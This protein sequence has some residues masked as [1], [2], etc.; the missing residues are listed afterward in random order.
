MFD[1]IGIALVEHSPQGIER[2]AGLEILTQTDARQRDR[3]YCATA[4]LQ[5][6]EEPAKLAP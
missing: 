2:L 1:T 5:I 6:L 3:A 4:L